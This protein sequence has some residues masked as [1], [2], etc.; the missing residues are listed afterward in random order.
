VILCGG[1]NDVAINNAQSALNSIRDF[2]S[3]NE[4]TN[5]MVTNVP[6]R[7]D[8]TQHSCVNS[9]IRFFNSKLVEILKPFNHVSILEMCGERKFFTNHGLHLNGLGKEVM[10]TKIVAHSS[11]L[12]NHKK[13]PPIAINCSLESASTDS[14]LGRV[15]N[16]TSSKATPA[17][18]SM[19]SQLGSVSTLTLTMETPATDS[20]DSQLGSVST[21]M[22]SQVTPATDPIDSQVG[23]VSTLTSTKVTPATDPID[24]HTY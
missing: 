16:L 15:S 22:P 13:N 9:E 12:L 1:A 8:L 2:V 10:A 23:N 20:V 21:L 6:H 11:L 14:Q 17:T 18:D 4:H 24:S 5:I 3:V 19:V 7:F